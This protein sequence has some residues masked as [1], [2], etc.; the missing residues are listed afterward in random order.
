MKNLV[1]LFLSFILLCSCVSDEKLT[2]NTEHFSNEACEECAIVDIE[3]PVPTQNRKI[4]R[5]ISNSMNE[6]VIALLL[7]EEKK[8]IRTIPQAINSF[9]SGYKDLIREF[10]D[11]SIPWE[12]R[13]KGEVIYENQH[14]ISIRLNSYLFTGG[15]HGYGSTHFLNFNKKNGEELGRNDLI[16]NRDKF[17]EFA[18]M[19]FRKQESIPDGASIN[20]TGFMFD[21]DDFY[22]PENIGFTE[23]GLQLL[24]NPYE[25]ASYADG[26]I[27]LTLPYK[28]VQEFLA[29]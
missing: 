24:Y 20:S 21:R 23:E 28:E 29:Y 25:V 10:P 8:S 18:E 7:F 22:L 15:A 17:E 3:L 9:E 4:G 2:F 14:L 5:T 6:E 16:K 11:E 13:I 26:V 27:E 19:K 12:A 1:S